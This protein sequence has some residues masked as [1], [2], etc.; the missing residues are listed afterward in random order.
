MLRCFALIPFSQAHFLLALTNPLRIGSGEPPYSFRI[1]PERSE[2]PDEINVRYPASFFVAVALDRGRKPEIHSHLFAKE[3]QSTQDQHAVVIISGDKPAFADHRCSAT[4]SILAAQ[5][6]RRFVHHLMIIPSQTQSERHA[7][8]VGPVG[9]VSLAQV[10]SFVSE[11]EDRH[12]DCQ[13]ELVR[14]RESELGCEIE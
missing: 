10:E 9:H 11:P 12:V 14:R 13:V 4:R 1:K 8:V 2:I 7:R 3:S 6:D 5:R